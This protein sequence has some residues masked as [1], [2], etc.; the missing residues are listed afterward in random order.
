MVCGLLGLKN[1]GFD[2]YRKMGRGSH[3]GNS[4][5]SLLVFP[6]GNMLKGKRQMV[7]IRTCSS[8]L[9]VAPYGNESADRKMNF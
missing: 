7:G 5:G 2:W 6:R 8:C 1:Y 3:S 4:R 9:S